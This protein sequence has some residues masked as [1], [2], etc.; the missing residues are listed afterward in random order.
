MFYLYSTNS[1][2]QMSQYQNEFWIRSWE[3][4]KKCKAIELTEGILLKWVILANTFSCKILCWF[5]H[6]NTFMYN[7]PGKF[8]SK[9][10]SNFLRSIYFFSYPGF[11][12]PSFGR[13]PTDLCRSITAD[14][15]LRSLFRLGAKPEPCPMQGSYQ[16]IDMFF[17]TYCR[18]NEP[19]RHMK[20]PFHLAKPAGKWSQLRFVPNTMTST[21]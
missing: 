2:S 16:V 20:K 7:I 15:P 4:Y 9:L 6:W 13:R 8:R 3:H 12:Q 14:A 5:F 11:C 18:I 21:V 1:V 19:C 17:L 10:S